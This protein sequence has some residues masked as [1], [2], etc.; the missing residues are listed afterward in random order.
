MATMAGLPAPE[1]RYLSAQPG[2]PSPC[3]DDS[4][5]KI[6]PTTLGNS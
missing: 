5:V 2:A 3:L 6:F 4:V 1:S